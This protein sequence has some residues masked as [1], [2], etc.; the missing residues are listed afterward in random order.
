MK[1]KS[2]D[3]KDIRNIRLPLSST[4]QDL[5]KIHRN[6]HRLSSCS[7]YLTFLEWTS[8]SWSTYSCTECF[9]VPSDESTRSGCKSTIS[10]RH[11]LTFIPVKDRQI[12]LPSFFRVNVLSEILCMM[13]PRVRNFMFQPKSFYS[14]V[15]SAGVP[16]DPSLPPPPSSSISIVNVQT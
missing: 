12:N 15:V 9:L 10:S 13:L 16:L 4:D 14:S 1:F 3:S 2:R 11:I 8:M 7:L 5:P 6:T